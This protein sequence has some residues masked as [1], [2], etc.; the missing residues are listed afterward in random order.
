MPHNK[1]NPNSKAKKPPALS[2]AKRSDGT[3]DPDAFKAVADQMHADAKAGLLAI[4]HAVYDEADGKRYFL[5][6]TTP[7]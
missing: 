4:D 5:M 1:P 2:T 6:V 7:I 3:W